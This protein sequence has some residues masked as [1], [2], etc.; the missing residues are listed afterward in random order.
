[1]PGHDVEFAVAAMLGLAGLSV[2]CFSGN[3][4]HRPAA[5]TFPY[6]SRSP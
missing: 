3:S 4:F 6:P 1:M 5:Q 2:G